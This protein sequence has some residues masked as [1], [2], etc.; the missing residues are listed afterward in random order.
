M[1]GN[2]AS[3]SDVPKLRIGSGFDIHAFVAGRKLILGT[4]DIPHTQGLAGHSDADV[5]LHAIIDAVLGALA[6]GDIG[7][8]FPD[9]DETY[10]G[11]SSAVLFQRVWQECSKK[12]WF[13]VNCDCVVVTE[14]PKLSAYIPQMCKA[15]ADLFSAS[16]EQISVKAK[17]SERLGAIGSK[18]GIA[19][20]SVVLMCQ[21]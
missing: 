18:E 12:G 20:T 9:S 15:V 10:R 13:L 17:T 19:A 11:I 7:R 1:P 3:P 21:K 5:L 8:W 4:V 2:S 16:V 6:W 14:E